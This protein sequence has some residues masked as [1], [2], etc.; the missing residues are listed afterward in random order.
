MQM[1]EYM[2]ECILCTRGCKLLDIID[3]QD[4]HLHIEGK[5][6]CQLV[7]DI[8]SIHVLCLEPVSRYVEDNQLRIFLLDGYTDRL[9]YVRLP[10]SR[11]AEKEE[12]VKSRL[13]GSRRNAFSGSDAHLVALP[14]HEIVETVFGLEPGV[15]LQ[16]VQSRIDER[17]GHLRGRRGDRHGRV[18]RGGH[19]LS[20]DAHGTV[21]DRTHRI[22]QP[23]LGPYDPAQGLA[24]H[25]EKGRLDVF[26]E[27]V[28]RNLD[29]EGA[30]VE[31]QRAYRLEP[32]RKLLRFE[33]L[34]HDVQTLFP[35]ADMSL[36]YFHLRGQINRNEA[37]IRIAL[38]KW[39][40]KI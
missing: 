35:Y 8:D 6:V 22:L 40:I 23:G 32:S 34:L 38:Q 28:R 1:I 20:G 7:I 16:P 2:K 24:E 30:P 25:V 37:V 12:R 29:R 10:E 26:A 9:G 3:Y 27:E 19:A 13:A 5:E 4:I 14:F 15:D 11:P 18:L 33:Y 39:G 36:C 17:V 21:L 31:R